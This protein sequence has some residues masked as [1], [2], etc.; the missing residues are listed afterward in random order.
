MIS[1]YRNKY[2]RGKQRTKILLL[3]TKWSTR[4]LISDKRQSSLVP[5]S[6]E[7]VSYVDVASVRYING[8]GGR[9][10]HDVLELQLIVDNNNT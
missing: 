5:D 1:L 4:H 8:G 7:V 2:R 9:N 3:L 6:K 10:I